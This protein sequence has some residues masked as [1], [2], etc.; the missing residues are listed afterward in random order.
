MIGV[1]LSAFDVLAFSGMH[2]RIRRLLDMQSCTTGELG[3]PQAR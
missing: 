3:T 1:C 2:I